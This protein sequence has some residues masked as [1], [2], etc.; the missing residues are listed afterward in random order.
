M[1]QQAEWDE[2]KARVN[3]AK[4][5]VSFW[6]A[7]TVFHDPLAATFHVDTHSTGEDRF[8]TVGLSVQGRVLI[9][10][11]TE[12]SGHPRII[13]ARVATRRERKVYETGS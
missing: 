1:D 12:R 7:E 13:S 4:H 9:V 11:H 3:L 8:L 2:E 5:R 6:E 10:V